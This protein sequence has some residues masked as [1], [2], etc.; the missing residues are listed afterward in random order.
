MLKAVPYV[1]FI[2]NEE[3]YRKEIKQ[4]ANNILTFTDEERF[5]IKPVI[6]VPDQSK[7]ESLLAFLSSYLN[8]P[9]LDPFLELTL[10]SIQSKI[11]A[12]DP[13]ELEMI[14]TNTDWNTSFDT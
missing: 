6:D 9:D 1:S 10:F 3:L 2:S 11:S 12:I 7:A 14:L 13:D 8:N 5:I 4:M